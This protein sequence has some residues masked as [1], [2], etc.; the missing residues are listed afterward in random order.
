MSRDSAK[1]LKASSTGGFFPPDKRQIMV[2]GGFAAVVVTISAL[3]ASALPGLLVGA[4]GGVWAFQT[5]RRLGRLVAEAARP[6][7]GASPDP[8]AVIPTA[9]QGLQDAMGMLETSGSQLV[10]G[11]AE[12]ADQLQSQ[13]Q[14]LV[15]LV[16][17][18]H[19]TCSAFTATVLA[20]LDNAQT[21]ASQATATLARA[22]AAVGIVRDQQA[23]LERTHGRL[24]TV[25][26][27][28]HGHVQAIRESGRA[29][30]TIAGQTSLLALN[31][32]IEAARSQASGRGFAVVAE[33][34]GDL[35]VQ[36]KG[37]AGRIGELN[38]LVEQ[39]I[40]ETVA[41]VGGTGQ[42]FGEQQA[43]TVAVCDALSDVGQSQGEMTALTLEVARQVRDFAGRQQTFTQ[44]L[45]AITERAAA[46]QTVFQ[47]TLFDL[48]EQLQTAD[49]CRQQLARIDTAL[50]DLDPVSPV[51]AA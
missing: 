13:I 30:S 23:A 36:A 5:G 49:I 25:A 29:V 35:A 18:H 27:G 17:Q 31:A 4:L 3:T 20:T 40:D 22:D 46:G 9:R 44:A 47:A 12:L 24:Q 33:A 43:A 10:G 32:R 1:I 51:A 21:V 37:A 26:H 11:L 45:D 28:L 14:S 50:A 41:T 38:G 48:F 2:V 16:G 34:F 7:A 15:D 8:D 39:G 19:Q 42:V 6:A